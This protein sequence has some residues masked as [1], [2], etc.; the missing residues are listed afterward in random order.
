[1]SQ[2]FGTL[3]CFSSRPFLKQLA[4][5]VS[6]NT[7][8]LKFPGM[9]FF[10]SILGIETF[11]LESFKV[12]CIVLMKDKSS[13]I[14]KWKSMMVKTCEKCRSSHFQS[15]EGSKKFEDW[16]EVKQFQNWVGL[17]NFFFFEGRGTF[18]GGGVSIP[19][20]AILESIIGKI[21]IGELTVTSLQLC[22]F[23][24]KWN[25]YCNGKISITNA[26]SLGKILRICFDELYS[27]A[28]QL[29]KIF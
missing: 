22:K 9:K 27:D 4:S 26:K 6:T 14:K 20:N 16:G 11:F 8:Q 25:C 24:L 21:L 29:K 10:S 7:L 3:S 13:Y 12:F 28:A 5:H 2:V 23:H 17:T 15:E 18:A 19:L 1:M